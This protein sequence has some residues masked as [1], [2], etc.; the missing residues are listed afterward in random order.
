VSNAQED[1][2]A[3]GG[4]EDSTTYEETGAGPDI[5]EA[6]TPDLMTAADSAYI[7]PGYLTYGSWNT[8]VI[9]PHRPA[10]AD[11][12]DLRLSWAPCDHTM[13]VCGRITSPFG[14]RH[15]RHH[16]GT[17]I[18]LQV[19]DPVHCAFAGMV[20]IS[21]YHR[22]FGNVVVV[23]HANGLETLYAHMS[24]RTVEEGDMVE[25]GEVIGLGGSTG[26]STGSHLHFE[27]RYL[28]H[29]IDPQRIFDVEEGVLRSDSLVV[30]PDL[31]AMTASGKSMA[32]PKTYTVRSGDT[33]YGISKR[34]GISVKSLCR[35]NRMSANRTL[36]IGQRLRIH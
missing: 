17:D 19:G 3:I 26:R 11:T 32:L 9:F 10:F 29:P 35:M 22:E 25:A 28:G 6:M 24:Q 12:V 7:I 13:P 4:P 30:D 21:R 18:K 15:G 23:R 8:D 34:T 33:L 27:V 2:T 14:V 1:T 16:Y 5:D 20:R 36:R 31:F